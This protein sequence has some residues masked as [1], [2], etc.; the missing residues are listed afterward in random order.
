[1]KAL[2]NRTAEEPEWGT[3]GEKGTV[4]PQQSGKGSLVKALKELP[5]VVGPPW[6]GT[7]TSSKSLC[8]SIPKC[9]YPSPRGTRG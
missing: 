6:I 5:R 4:F 2:A 7:V 1:M 9:P 8:L 3:D